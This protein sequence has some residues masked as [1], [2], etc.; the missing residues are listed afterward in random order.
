MNY[1]IISQVQ[2]NFFS[3]GKERIK[4]LIVRWVMQMSVF[5]YGEPQVFSSKDGGSFEVT[6]STGYLKAR[7]RL[8]EVFPA[9]E[10]YG[11]FQNGKLYH[12]VDPADN[13]S[14]KYIDFTNTSLSEIRKRI[15]PIS[16]GSYAKQ[17]LWLAAIFGFQSSVDGFLAYVVAD[18]PDPELFKYH[19]N[20]AIGGAGLSISFLMATALCNYFSE[21]KNGMISILKNYQT[22]L[23]E[24]KQEEE[25]FINPS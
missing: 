17:A 1:K 6:D 22:Y 23:D 4:Q 10:L 24:V 12:M 19:R 20:F 5:K 8:L 18:R 16:W 25:E 9:K 14:V 13:S 7:G 2:Q 15:S 11:F 3:K 21:K